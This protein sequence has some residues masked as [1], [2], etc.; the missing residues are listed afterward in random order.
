M[1]KTHKTIDLAPPQIF[2]LS[3]FFLSVYQTEVRGIRVSTSVLRAN[4]CCMRL[5]LLPRSITAQVEA[6]GCAGL[7]LKRTLASN[8]Y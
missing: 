7:L 8:S 6:F 1:L 3:F 5:R 4:G 2:F